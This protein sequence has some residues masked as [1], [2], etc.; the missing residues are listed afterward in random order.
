[1]PGTVH[2][3]HMACQ[4]HGL[5]FAWRVPRLRGTGDLYAT[6]KNMSV[7]GRSE[8]DLCVEGKTEGKVEGDFAETVVPYPRVQYSISG[9]D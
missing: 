7:M 4:K 5:D 1:M 2:I 8:R 9:T 3:L 6:G